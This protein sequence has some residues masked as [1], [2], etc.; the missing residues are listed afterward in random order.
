M[1]DWSRDAPILLVCI[2]RPEL[3]DRRSAWAGG[4]LNATTVLLEPLTT[5]ETDE[6]MERLL[7]DSALAEPLRIRIREAAE[8]NPLFVEQ[9]LAMVAESPNGDVVV[10]PTIQ[11]L[12]AARL[13]QLDPS[14]RGVLERGSVEGKIFHRGG[15]EALA[16]DERDVPTKLMALVRKELVRPDRTQLPGDDAFRFRHL[17]IRDAAYDGSAQGGARRVA[18]ALRRLAR[19]ARSRPDRTRRDSRLP[20]RAGASLPRRARRCRRGDRR[21]CPACRRAARR[22]AERA[23][24]RDDAAAALVLYQRTLALASAD[25]RAFEWRVRLLR[26]RQH[27]GDL[28]GA[29]QQADELIE[30]AQRDGDRAKELR[31]RVERGLVAHLAEAAGQPEERLLVEEALEVLGPAADDAGLA[32]TWLLAAQTELSALQWRAMSIA[33]DNAVK[34]ARRAGDLV[35]LEYARGH[36]L[37]PRVLGPFPA[38][39]ALEFLAANA[40]SSP[41]QAAFRSQLEAMLGN[42]DEA[43]ASVAEARMRARELGE[44]LLA[45][46]MSMQA[47]EVELLADDAEAALELATEGIAELAELGER[48][49]LSTVTCFGAEPRTGSA[50]TT[51][52][53]VSRK[54]PRRSGRR[55]T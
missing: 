44:R 53:G 25:S 37:V 15:V 14:E 35:L 9:M 36:C 17:L 29:L 52:P 40:V 12:L 23:A 13:D 50:G 45:G 8:G 43:R 18:R 7:G 6:L 3:L 5:E 54:R 49:W 46:G 32:I 28:T 39:E 30:S 4:K 55:T 26:L 21:S 22:A 42:F 24:L 1:A 51:K 10:P 41:F 47:A 27:S 16:P 34:H 31:A 20:P 38:T 33:A 19:G 11:A 48:G 2:A